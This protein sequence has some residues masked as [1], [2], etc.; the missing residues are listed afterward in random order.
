MQQQQQPEC[1]SSFAVMSFAFLNFY[2]F[3]LTS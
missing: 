2:F 1:L 3:F